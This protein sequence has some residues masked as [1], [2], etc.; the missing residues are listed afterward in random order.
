MQ[1][2]KGNIAAEIVTITPEELQ[3][4]EQDL[5]NYQI[6]VLERGNSILFLRKIER[7][8]ADKSFG[9]HVAQ[10]AGLPKPVVMRARE[11]LARIEANQTTQR[12]IGSDILGTEL[13]PKQVNMFDAPAMD[14]VEEIRN[15]DVM[16]MTPIDALN[17]L[18]L[19]KEKALKL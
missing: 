3:A 17:T 11:I 16:S 14:L 13:P 4:V 2:T 8:G 5:V 15:L 6:T 9:I 19:L 7:G 12:R 10:L 18:F 1:V